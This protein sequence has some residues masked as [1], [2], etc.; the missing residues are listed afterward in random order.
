MKMTKA[1]GRRRMAEVKSKCKK[2]FMM[3]Y[4]SMKDMDTIERIMN[5]RSRQLK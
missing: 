3:D 4:I 2:L 1:Q 5:S